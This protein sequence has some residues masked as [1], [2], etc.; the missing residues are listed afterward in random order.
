VPKVRSITLE[1]TNNQRVRPTV[2]SLYS[3]EPGTGRFE[4]TGTLQAYFESNDLYQK[5]LDHGGGAIALTVGAATTKKYTVSMPNVQF[6]NGSRVIGGNDQDI[7]V[8][9]PYRAI[10]DGTAACTLQF[11]RAVA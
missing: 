3:E 2:G 4:V 5:V 8:E 9:I 10:Y 1:I 11:T 6:L 7:M